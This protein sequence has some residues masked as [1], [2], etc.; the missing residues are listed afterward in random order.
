MLDIKNKSSLNFLKSNFFILYLS[1]V[2][3]SSMVFRPFFWKDNLDIY[4]LSQ[5]IVNTFIGISLILIFRL[6]ESGKKNYVI[7]FIAFAFLNLFFLHNFY[8]FKF[9]RLEMLFTIILFLVLSFFTLFICIGLN[10]RNF[11]LNFLLALDVK[12]WPQV[13]TVILSFVLLRLYL[14]GYSLMPNFNEDRVSQIVWVQKYLNPDFGSGDFLLSTNYPLRSFFALMVGSLAEFTSLEFAYFALTL[15]NLIFFMTSVVFFAKQTN[16]LNF[17]QGLAIALALSILSFDRLGYGIQ[18][19]NYSMF[20]L[21]P[22]H[23][24]ISFVIFGLSCVVFKQKRPYLGSIFLVL[25]FL[26]QPLIVIYALMVTLILFLLMYIFSLLKHTKLILSSRATLSLNIFLALFIYAIYI[27]SLMNPSTLIFLI[28]VW[29]FILIVVFSI[30][31]FYLEPHKF[32]F[33]D[34]SSMILISSHSLFMIFFLFFVNLISR[35]PTEFQYKSFFDR[36]RAYDLILTFFRA[37]DIANLDNSSTSAIFFLSVFILLAFLLVSKLNSLVDVK[38]IFITII[39][40]NIH[41]LIIIASDNLIKHT[42]L[43]GFQILW[44]LSHSYIISLSIV[45]LTIYFSKYFFESKFLIIPTLILISLLD[46]LNERYVI[47][48]MNLSL[49]HLTILLVFFTLLVKTPLQSKDYKNV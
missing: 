42:N 35:V 12:T 14:E 39:I 38:P 47:Y 19:F 49:T 48:F 16:F 40:L 21:I 32:I 34:K 11:S 4:E 9:S 13:I 37:S 43:G 22:R 3:I 28:T 15:A 8:S 25:G 5:I 1:S 33:T 2:I 36:L 18:V 31:K 6:L 20:N 24:A 29:I 27:F 44:P 10:R 7:F 23:I 17:N 26:T 45:F 41:L 30:A 46:Y